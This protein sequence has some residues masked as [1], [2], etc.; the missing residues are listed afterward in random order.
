MIILTHP[1]YSKLDFTVYDGLYSF[2]YLSGY[3]VLY[4]TCVDVRTT[5]K[6]PLEPINTRMVLVGAN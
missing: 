6:F 3:K 2:I 4:I 1:Y 5:E